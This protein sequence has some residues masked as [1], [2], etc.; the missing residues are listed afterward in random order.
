VDSEITYYVTY[1]CP[2]CKT[3]LEAKHGGWQ[4]WLRC[5]ICGAPSLPPEILLGHPQ[6]R[7]QV[8]DSPETAAPEAIDQPKLGSALER[9][10]VPASSS[11]T[12]PLRLIF[13]TGLTL[14]LFLL[15]VAYIDQKKQTTA[16]F[17]FLSIVFF[18]LLLR[19]PRSRAAPED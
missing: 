13:L 9:V 3:E 5:P 12:S 14:S 8:G 1:A 10:W 15:L 11:P 7:R 17:G 19:T 6:T 2:Q 16:I 18:L 4:G